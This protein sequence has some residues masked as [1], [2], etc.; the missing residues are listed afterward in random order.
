[1]LLLLIL[2]FT[3]LAFVYSFVWLLYPLVVVLNLVLLAPPALHKGSEV[4]SGS[5]PPLVLIAFTLPVPALYPIQAVGNTLLA[6]LLLFVG[7][8]FKLRAIARSRPSDKCS[9]A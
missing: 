3:R 9:I 7:L 1:M 8:G 4:G 6:C 2:I 5:E